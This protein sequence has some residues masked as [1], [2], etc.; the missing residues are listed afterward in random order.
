MIMGVDVGRKVG[1]GVTDGVGE[2]VNVM[3]EVSVIVG[4]RVGAGS[5]G[6]RNVVQAR[7]LSS[8][9]V[10]LSATERRGDISNSSPAKCLNN[11]RQA[12]DFR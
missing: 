5:P 8:R 12:L 4:G 9:T 2:G 6:D 3:V 7:A 10:R 1:V 11:I